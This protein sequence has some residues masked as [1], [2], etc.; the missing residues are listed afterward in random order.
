MLRK[1]LNKKRRVGLM[2]LGVFCKLFESEPLVFSPAFWKKAV[3][4]CFE[5]VYL[6]KL[7]RPLKPLEIAFTGAL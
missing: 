5:K 3:G 4:E 2:P 6:K 1:S 7:T